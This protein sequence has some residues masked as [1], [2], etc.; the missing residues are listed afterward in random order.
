L[1]AKFDIALEPPA[2]I[3]GSDFERV[4][5]LLGVVAL[6]EQFAD[7]GLFRQPVHVIFEL[8]KVGVAFYVSHVHPLR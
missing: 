1:H 2:V 6:P 8:F 7:V 3:L 4:A 5:R